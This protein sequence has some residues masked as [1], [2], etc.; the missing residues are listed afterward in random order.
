VLRLLLKDPKR[1]WKVTE[2]AQ[3]A[4]VSLGQ[5]SKIRT[6]LINREWAR[7]SSEGLVLSEPNR[8]LDSW[9]TEHST[10]GLQTSH[11]STLHGKA[12]EEA[13]RQASQPGPR[14]IPVVLASFSAAQWLAPFGRTGSQYVY[15]SEDG[16]KRLQG[17]LRLSSPTKGENVIV[18]IPRDEGVFRDAVEPAPG[19]YCTS[20]VQ[21]YLDL[22]LAGERGREAAEHLRREK[23]AW[24]EN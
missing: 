8:L 10:A 6:A 19:I 15:A 11:Y 13:L 21:T 1:A 3:E 20:P 14:G 24:L 7:A 5:V 9:R 18:T 23:L 16:I 22:F 17:I 4:D 2:L 12:F